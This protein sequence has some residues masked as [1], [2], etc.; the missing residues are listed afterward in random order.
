MIFAFMP[1]RIELLIL[2]GLCTGAVIVIGIV[3]AIIAINS[4]RPKG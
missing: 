1:S 3:A 4:N 2:G